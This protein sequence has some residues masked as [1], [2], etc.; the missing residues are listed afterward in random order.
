MYSAK[1]LTK[2]QAMII[3]FVIVAAGM[4][5]LYST[6]TLGQRGNSA[7]TFPI[8]F[9]DDLGRN[10]TISKLPE[11][12]VSL[13]P[14]AT[15]IVFAV[16]A[17]DK[18][19]GVTRYDDYPPELVDKVNEGVIVTVGGGVDPDI[20]QITSL[21]PD[22]I[23]VDGPG[24]VSSKPLARLQELGFTL[25]ALHANSIEGV[26]KDLT[27]V[28]NMVGNTE[29]AG[30]VVM[31]M[32]ERINSI[33]SKMIDATRVKVYIE[34][35]H[36]P[37]FSVGLGSIQDEM[38]QKA[39]G[40]N[41]FSDLKDSAQITAEAVIARN[42]DVI[43]NF[44]NQI[45]VDDIKKRPGWENINAVKNSKV[46]EMNPQEGAP[47]P[48][49]ADSLEKMAKLIHP[50]LFVAQQSVGSSQYLNPLV[51]VTSPLSQERK[52]EA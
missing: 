8:T 35:W 32:R 27:L 6:N 3:L 47:N 9:T 7:S 21:K 12:I 31:S 39:G 34:N 1:G 13:V 26:L 51:M 25:V 52:I 36:D 44:N 29:K 2:F 28:G 11:R 42:P 15:Q 17:G 30:Q 37:L 10:V 43:I 23:L 45:G 20:E 18:V 4:T 14:S 50:E 16:G 22:I 49:I 19:V 5:G 48:R 46:F 33:E 24:H 38:V 41:I 40:T